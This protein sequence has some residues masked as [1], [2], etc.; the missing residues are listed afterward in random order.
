HCRECLRT[1]RRKP[2]TETAEQRARRKERQSR[3]E[4]QKSHLE[5]L[6]R[7]ARRYPLAASATRIAQNALLTGKIRKAP[8]CQAL[9][10]YSTKHIQLHH[11]DYTRPLEILTVCALH[12]KRGHSVGYIAVAPG[13]P[14][15]LGNIPP[16]A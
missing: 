12:H 9:G 4:W 11:H 15:H 7:W 13:V 6:G 16:R 2:K 8:H 14:P 3:P 10:C 1:G 5:A